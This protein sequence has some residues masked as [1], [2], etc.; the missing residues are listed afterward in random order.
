MLTGV[1]TTSYGPDLPGSPTLGSLV[2]RILNNVPD[3][4][5]LRLSSIDSIEVD[6]ELREI[7][8]SEPRFMPHLHLSLQSGDDMI[9]KRMKRR[10]LRDDTLRFCADLKAARP[11]IAFG[12]D[13]MAGFPTETEEMFGNSMSLIDEAQLSY[14]HVFPFSPRPE[15]PAARMPQLDRGLIKERA[16][17]LRARADKSLDRHLRSQIGRKLKVLVEKRNSDG[18]YSAHAEDFASVTLSGQQ[19]VE[20]GQIV[21][22]TANDVRAGKLV[23]AAIV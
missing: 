6:A 10:H 15:T 2:R 23:A 1:D 7:I 11:D 4:K 9:L 5:R 12:A 22:A 21:K 13:L 19:P 16:S 18:T 3:L 8:I 17:R 20:P 14:V